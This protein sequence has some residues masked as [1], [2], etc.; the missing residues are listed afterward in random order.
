MASL[1]QMKKVGELSAQGW[2]GVSGPMTINSPIGGWVHM[3]NERNQII[4]VSAAGL[5][6]TPTGWDK[7]EDEQLA[8][9]SGQ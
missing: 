7:Y 4:R 2:K 8:S 1:T 3:M 5:V 6:Q 9:E